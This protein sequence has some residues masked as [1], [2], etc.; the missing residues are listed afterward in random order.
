MIIHQLQW[1]ALHCRVKATFHRT[2]RIRATG[3]GRVF[4]FLFIICTTSWRVAPPR[5]FFQ[6]DYFLLITALKP[7]SII[8]LALS[9]KALSEGESSHDRESKEIVVDR[10]VG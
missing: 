2:A 4:V 10:L 6:S 9:F 7:T 5:F 3:D 8:H 1:M